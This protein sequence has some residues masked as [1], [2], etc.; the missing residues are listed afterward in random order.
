MFSINIRAIGDN[1]IISSDQSEN[2]QGIQ[3]NFFVLLPKELLTPGI[4]PH[5]DQQQYIWH[6]GPE[7]YTDAVIHIISDTTKHLDSYKNYMVSAALYRA[8][9]TAG[10]LVVDQFWEMYIVMSRAT[11]KPASLEYYKHADDTTVDLGYIALFKK[12]RHQCLIQQKQQN[13]LTSNSRWQTR[14]EVV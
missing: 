7:H 8:G 11:L 3:A 1:S 13:R 14:S 12:I 4:P 9:Y 5:T 10:E 2:I 6:K